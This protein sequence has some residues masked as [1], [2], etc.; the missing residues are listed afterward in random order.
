MLKKILMLLVFIALSTILYLYLP[1]TIEHKKVKVDIDKEL[2]EKATKSYLEKEILKALNSKK[3]DDAKSFLD[4]A[5]YLNVD[6]NSS[7]IKLYNKEQEPLNKSI[8]QTKEFFKGFISGKS[9]SS[10]A[11]AGSVVSDFTLVGDV[12]DLYKE[13]GAYLKGQDYNKI[14]LYLSAIGV[15]LSGATVVSLG[16]SAPIKVGASTLKS[17]NKSAKLSKGFVKVLDKKLSKSVDLKILKQIDFSSFNS[18]KKGSKALY[19]SINLKP[20]E[21]LLKDINKI[22]KNSSTIDTIRVLK[23]IDNEQDLRRVVKLSSKYKKNTKS[24][25]KVLGKG[26]LRG[27]KIVVKKGYKYFST[28]IGLIISA[29]ISIWIFFSLIFRAIKVVKRQIV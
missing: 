12:R 15:A 24:V 29:I 3:I 17:A 22:K 21:A 14:T 6:I 20:I 13:G 25:L 18:I 2:R 28:L 8:R 26:A 1:K 19:K 27:T 4:L 9:E 23:Y 16:A 5:K 10:S 7:I 11:L